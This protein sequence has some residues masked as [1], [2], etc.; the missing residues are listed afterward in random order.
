M[1]DAMCND[2]QIV[3]LRMDASAF[4]RDSAHRQMALF[5]RDRCRVARDE[6]FVVVLSAKKTA[7]RA[8]HRTARRIVRVPCVRAL[9]LLWA[10]SELRSVAL[11]ALQLEAFGILA[12]GLNSNESGVLWLEEEGRSG[13]ITVEPKWLKKSLA[14][15][16]VAIVPG[17]LATKSDGTIVTVASGGADLTAV[18][19]AQSLGASRCE[20]VK[21]FSESNQGPDAPSAG[22]DIRTAQVGRAKSDV[23]SESI[24]KQALDAARTANIPL[25]LRSVRKH[26]RV[27]TLPAPPAGRYLQLPSAS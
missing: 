2:Y 22:E 18:L 23:N 7:T 8:L 16:T 15:H 24:K 19:L 3:A 26:V 21:D 4:A 6:R 25:V 5:V 27:L 11:L 13:A 12:K 14:E 9:D 17:S 1:C 10:T 20:F